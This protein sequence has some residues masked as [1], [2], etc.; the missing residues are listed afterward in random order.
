MTTPSHSNLDASGNGDPDAILLQSLGTDILT[1]FIPVVV[2]TW[3]VAVYTILVFKTSQILTSK[4]SSH[5]RGILAIVLVM[6][7]MDVVLWIID[8]RNVVV[9]LDLTLIR[10]G[11]KSLNDRYT[12]ANSEILRLSIVEDALYSYLVV[13]GDFIIV[14]RVFVF[15]SD[16]LRERLVLVVPCMVYAGSIVRNYLGTESG[17]SPVKKIFIILVDTGVIYVLYFVIEVFFGF[18]SI[19]SAISAHHNLEFA[20][21]IYQ[22]TTS[23]I[24]GIYPT[25]VVILVHTHSS[26]L[27]SPTIITAAS[28]VQFTAA[29]G[30]RTWR[31]GSEK[32]ANDMGDSDATASGVVSTSGDGQPLSDATREGREKEIPFILRSDLKGSERTIIEYIN[33]SEGGEA[34]ASEEGGRTV[35]GPYAV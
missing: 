29:P 15:W 21:L 23:S 12:N 8:V 4:S 35:D 32:H 2:E 20:L 6:Y 7:A 1:S 19:N 3:L 10:G 27:D 11:S 33:N 25:I 18:N 30:A 31:S 17:Q 28:S 24:V 26:L 22:Y 14:S 13:L 16:G 5:R 34:L 9:K